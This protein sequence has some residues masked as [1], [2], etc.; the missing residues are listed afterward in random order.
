MLDEIFRLGKFLLAVCCKTEISVAPAVLLR[1]A[2]VKNSRN[3]VLRID[4]IVLSL[5]TE[6]GRSSFSFAQE[7][8]VKREPGENPGRSRRCKLRLMPF[9]RVQIG[10]CP[11][12][13]EGLTPVE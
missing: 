2:A 1:S 3:I 5:R 11:V 13:W 4:G 8:K 9:G 12:G 10:H 7:E 6:N